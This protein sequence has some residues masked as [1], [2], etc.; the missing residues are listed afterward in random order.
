MNTLE[1]IT[2]GFA[3]WVWL[4]NTSL[5]IVWLHHVGL[6]TSNALD[7]LCTCKPQCRLLSIISK[8]F[9][10]PTEEKRSNPNFTIQ[11]FGAYY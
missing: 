11:N 7:L 8:V 5:E 6:T 1:P 2:N 10:G 9:F 3:R 4:G